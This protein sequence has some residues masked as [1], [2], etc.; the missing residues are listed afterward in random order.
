MTLSYFNPEGGVYM[1][2]KTDGK[3]IAQNKKARHDYFVDETY[4][5]DGNHGSDR[6]N[7]S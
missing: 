2:K 5:A 6:I 4:E 7:V 3:I 1:A